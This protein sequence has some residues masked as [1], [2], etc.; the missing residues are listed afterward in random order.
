[1]ESRILQSK[2][3]WDAYT[4]SL[5]AEHKLWEER[6]MFDVDSTTII[7][8][9]FPISLLLEAQESPELPVYL[10]ERLAIVIWTR[11]VLLNN[12]AVL[13]RIAPQLLETAP[14]SYQTPAGWWV[15]TGLFGYTSTGSRFVVQ[16]QADLRFE[17]FAN[18][19]CCPRKALR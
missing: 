10:R 4:E 18:C 19:R 15:R 2:S 17:P 16:S 14:V 3:E 5:Y 11:A 1:M 12:D 9:R 6:L 8:E 13:R 7:N